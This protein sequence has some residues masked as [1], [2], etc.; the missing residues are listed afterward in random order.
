MEAEL[1]LRFLDERPKPKDPE[2]FMRTS[3]LRW[4]SSEPSFEPSF[5]NDDLQS[6]LD[7]FIDQWLYFLPLPRFARPFAFKDCDLK[8]CIIKSISAIDFQLG[9]TDGPVSPEVIY[10]C[11]LVM[12]PHLKSLRD[13][14]FTIESH[15][16]LACL[17]ALDPLA[18]LSLDLNV[19]KSKKFPD[20]ALAAIKEE[21]EIDGSSNVLHQVS[22]HLFRREVS[23]ISKPKEDYISWLEA[24]EQGL[25]NSEIDGHVHGF[26]NEISKKHALP[27]S[28]LRPLI[29]IKNFVDEVLDIQ[30][31]S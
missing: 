24:H 20:Y 9:T 23:K 19:I 2:S 25:T 10:E 18:C 4:C 31:I 7:S 8:Q 13:S 28:R 21:C 16:L 27:I 1:I 26:L 3:A 17:M 22:E 5:P 11:F 12:W 6:Q 30:I 14:S 29:G 15:S